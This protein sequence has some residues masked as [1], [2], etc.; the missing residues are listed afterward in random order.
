M[1]TLK[2]FVSL[3]LITDQSFG[4]IVD[5][6]HEIS[7]DDDIPIVIIINKEINTTCTEE[8]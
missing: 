6:N 7:N 4:L 2:K 1:K 3:K 8:S 5:L